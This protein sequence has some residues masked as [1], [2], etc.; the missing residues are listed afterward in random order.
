[1]A[2]KAKKLA[3]PNDEL[4]GVKLTNDNA[5]QIKSW[6]GVAG[7]ESELTHKTLK[8]GG[9]AYRVRV[10]TSKGW[11]VAELGDVIARTKV[12]KAKKAPTIVCLVIKADLF[13]GFEK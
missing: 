10:K 9:L 11:R 8:G 2:I 7:V 5:D 1:M 12:S 3:Y 4:R 13:S 6:L